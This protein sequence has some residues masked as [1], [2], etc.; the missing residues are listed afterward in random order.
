MASNPDLTIKADAEDGVNL[1]RGK[2]DPMQAYMLG[3]IKVFGDLALGMKL[4]NF[5]DM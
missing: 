2:L 1:L 5:F 3:K 4:I